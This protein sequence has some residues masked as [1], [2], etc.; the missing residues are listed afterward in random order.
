MK[1]TTRGALLA[2]LMLAPLVPLA[3]AGVPVNPAWSPYTAPEPVTALALADNGRTIAAALGPWSES[4]QCPTPP[5]QECLAA[6]AQPFD[7]AILHAETGFVTRYKDNA[8]QVSPGGRLFVAVSD[9]GN[10]IASIGYD[11]Q[12]TSGTPTPATPRLYYARAGPGGSW[13][14]GTANL[15]AYLSGTPVGLA[16]SDDGNRVAL[17]LDSSGNMTV[18]GFSFAS[19]ILS[20]AFTYIAPGRPI[21]LAGS[22]NLGRLALVGVAP[23]GGGVNRSVAF[24]LSFATGT[25]DT[26]H[27]AAEGVALGAVAVSPD[28]E[29][30]AVGGTNG[31][32][33]LFRGA[34]GATQP[35]Q[36]AGGN[37]TVSSLVLSGDGRRL[38]AGSDGGVTAFDLVAAAPSLLWQAPMG[39]AP[40]SMDY[41]HTGGLLLIGSSDGVRALNEAGGQMWQLRGNTT[42]VAVDADATT[43]AYAQGRLVFSGSLTRGLTFAFKGGGDTRPPQT[44]T[45]SG[46]AAYSLS[47]QN[48]GA[49]TE[50]ITF[51]GP[52][53]LDVDVRFEPAELLV[54]P[55]ET[56]D[57]VAYVRPGQL[58]AGSRTFNV[59]AFAATSGLSD[60]TTLSFDI[61]PFSDVSLFLNVTEVLA[62]QGEKHELLLEVLNTGTEAVALSLRADASTSDGST[63]NVTVDPES[64]TLNPNSKTTVRATVTP[65]R[66]AANGTSNTITYRLEGAQV[67]DS[68]TVVYRINPQTGIELIP[69]ARVKYIEAGKSDTFNITVRNTGSLPRRFEVI[70]DI[71]HTSDRLWGIEMPTEAFRLDPLESRTITMKVTVP[72][73]ARPPDYL[74]FTVTAQLLPEGDEPVVKS[75][76]P[77][78]ANAQEPK[79]DEEDE[80]EDNLIPNPSIGLLAA[81]GALAALA[82]RRRRHA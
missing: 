2:L 3:N 36:L 82:T 20:N 74:K 64:F 81:L 41:N 55:D 63:W 67:A 69:A 25:A 48:P 43:I 8:E 9:D 62:V 32:L 10:T 39:V 1:R 76:V 79:P 72:V 45:P 44:I 38:A 66:N 61:A 70:Y 15:S 65:P 35:V 6:R 57:V 54:N 59:T 21:A 37:G 56:V 23:V 58:Q 18:R 7:L 29:R 71:N 80:E 53:D 52:P 46:E 50:R 12:L 60:D 31:T 51:R 68:V 47:V 4:A 28:G 11:R 42:S 22:D 30:V 5:T 19:G 17:A 49:V 26:Q 34:T 27:A 75:S 73:E 14:T 78:F 40:R 16:L 33:L 13:T 24:T 77:I